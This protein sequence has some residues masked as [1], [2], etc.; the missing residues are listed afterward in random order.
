MGMNRH[1]IACQVPVS[2]ADTAAN[3]SERSRGPL[4]GLAGTVMRLRGAKRRGLAFLA[5]AVAVVSQPPFDVPVVLFLSFPVLVWLIDGADEED[6]QDIWRRLMPAFGIGWWFGFGY[7]V[8]GLW[9]LGNA[10]LIEAEQFAWALPFAVFG[11][12]AVLATFYGLAVGLARALWSDGLGR[13]GALA[14]GFGLAEW[15]R[16][17]VLT[18]FPWNAI[19]YGA[20]PVPLLMQSSAVVGLFGMSALT[21]FVASVPA[22]LAT[23]RGA[24]SG[25]VLACALVGAHVAYGSWVLSR[26]S[27]D[28]SGGPVLRLVQPSVDQSMKWDEAAQNRIFDTLVDLSRAPAE[29]AAPSL[30]VWPET[31]IPFLL[32]YRPDVLARLSDVLADGQ[33]LIAG[34]VR[35]ETVAPGAW[36]HYYNAIYVIGDDGRILEA[37]DKHHLVPFGEYLPF[38]ALLERIGLDIIANAPGGFTPGP[39]RH[40]VPVPGG[41]HFLPLVCYEA[42]FPHEMAARGSTADFVINVTN[43]A[44]FGA[45]PGPYQHFR[46]A[47]LRAVETRLPLLRVAN[48]GISA[49]VDAYGRILTALPLN[50]VDYIDAELP[51]KA[52]RPLYSLSSL[53]FFWIIVFLLA[54]ASVYSRYRFIQ[55]CD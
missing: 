8:C 30:I 52:N 4:R 5:G 9:W 47:Q 27:D 20:M 46:Q 43:D 14:L 51:E 32:T 45:T 44:W 49:V 18:G 19:G 12:P 48:N 41:L 39:P 1:S 24:L 3:R 35:E 17:F 33:T 36:P 31:A 11:L 25:L 29:G 6:G 53:E 10:L 40:T 23:R 34:A 2:R 22:L 16:S 13:I 37:A 15:L 21:V 55:R 42:I 26:V 38:S 54:I 7:F 28:G 50:A